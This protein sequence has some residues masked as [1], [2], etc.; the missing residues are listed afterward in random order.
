MRNFNQKAPFPAQAYQGFQPGGLR[1]QLGLP[2]GSLVWALAIRRRVVKHGE[3]DREPQG[4]SENKQNFFI[5]HDHTVLPL[6]SDCTG[7]SEVFSSAGAS[8]TD[9]VIGGDTL[10]S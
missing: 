8:V 9:S 6:V 2:L 7:S 5:F 3:L 4:Q 10:N 1:A